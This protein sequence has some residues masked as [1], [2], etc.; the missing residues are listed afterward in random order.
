MKC[1]EACNKM[2]QPIFPASGRRKVAQ[3]QSHWTHLTVEWRQ[4]WLGAGTYIPAEW[5]DTSADAVIRGAN[6]DLMI[7]L[8]DGLVAVMP[9]AML[10]TTSPVKTMRAM[11][12]T[13]SFKSPTAVWALVTKIVLANVLQKNGVHPP[14]IPANEP[15]QVGGHPDVVGLLDGIEAEASP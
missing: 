11:A 10:S 2:L 9:G 8:L 13:W 1:A 15:V 7:D 6:A 4:K 14:W 3:N 5:P 12:A